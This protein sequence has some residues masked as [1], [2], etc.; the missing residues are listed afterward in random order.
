[1]GAANDKSQLL[2]DFN[3]EKASA[4]EKLEATLSARFEEA[5]AAA[6]AEAERGARRTW[7][8]LPRPPPL[9]PPSRRGP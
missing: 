7:R 8:R 9:P 4:L 6:L 1:M 2:L 3:R 5:R